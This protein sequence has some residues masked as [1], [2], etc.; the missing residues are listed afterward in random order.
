MDKNTE[1]FLKE[2]K[3]FE[4]Y[5]VKLSGMTGNYVSY[6]KALTYCYS[7]KKSDLLMVKDNYNFLKNAGDLRNLLSH[8][9]GI[10]SPS[11]EFLKKFKYLTNTIQFPTKIMDIA[12]KYENII[13][14][15]LESKVSNL[16]VLMKKNNITHVPV[17]EDRKMI[18]VF[19]SSSFFDHYNGYSS[20]NI[21]ENT[22]LK[23]F[24]K[25]IQ[26]ESHNSEM[27]VF[28]SK[29]AYVFEF[30]NFIGK[31][32]E[33]KGKRVVQI[34]ITS[35]GKRDGKLLGIVSPSDFLKIK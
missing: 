17:L 11:D 12:T 35:T 7:N 19:S 18:G 5:I 23:E 21:D 28:C 14:A 8:N 15:T 13:T 29:D 2:F 20:L 26:F 32:L 16:V 33:L 25:D 9:D 31:K 24:S 30:V 27:Y 3:E 34:L 22:T 10:C 6:Y 1:E 4:A